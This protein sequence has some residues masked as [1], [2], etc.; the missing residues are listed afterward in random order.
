MGMD[1]SV[2]PTNSKV[3]VWVYLKEVGTGPLGGMFCP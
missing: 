1:S 2:F 3:G